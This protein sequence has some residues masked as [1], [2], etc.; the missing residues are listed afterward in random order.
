M[1]RPLV[2]DTER[3]GRLRTPLDDLMRGIAAIKNP[4]WAAFKLCDLCYKEVEDD[5]L[6]VGELRTDR[7]RSSG[8]TAVPRLV[9]RAAQTACASVRLIDTLLRNPHCTQYTSTATP[10]SSSKRRVG[11]QHHTRQHH[12][13]QHQTHPASRSDAS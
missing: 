13:R 1:R 12:T 2:I 4:Q 3:S 8:A 6:E 5:S 10:S 11:R 7:V 9:E